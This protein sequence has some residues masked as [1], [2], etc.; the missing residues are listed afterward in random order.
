MPSHSRDNLNALLEGGTPRWMP[1]TVDV[2]ALPGF[3]PPIRRQFAEW[4]GAADPAEYFH[5]DFRT[6][7]LKARFAGEDPQAWH[8]H[9]EPGTTFD[10]WGI[11]HSAGGVEGTVDRTYPPLARAESVREIEA[12]PSPALDAAID[13]T[14]IARYQERGY[15]VFG[16]AGSIYE[17]SWWLRGM[18]TFLA[19]T[20]LNPSLTEA[21]IAKVADYTRQL[22]LA[23]A[24]AGIDVLCFYDDAGAQT[25]MQISP[26]MWRRLIKPRWAMVLDHVRC[27]FPHVRTFLHSCGCIRDIVPDIVDLGFDILHP[28][29]PE[30]MDFAEVH[31]EFGKRITLCATISSQRTFPFGTPDDVRRTV[32]ELKQLCGE[33]KRGILCPSN[34]I[35]PETPWENVLAFVEA[36][37]PVR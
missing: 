13:L 33:G 21:L 7:S 31:R 28:I 30:C 35:Q 24:Q 23:S 8:D 19:D 16:Y 5:C 18:E 29:Q 20:I 9:I 37:R 12:Y 22:A 3:T 15:P 17:W 6:F 34:M 26:A 32:R 4:T 36:A 11:G 14:P 25:G 10:E 27:R 2:G 1:F